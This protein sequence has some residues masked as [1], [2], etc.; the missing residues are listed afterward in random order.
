M[1]NKKHRKLG[2]D[3]NGISN[4]ESKCQPEPDSVAPLHLVDFEAWLDAELE[5]LEVRFADWT[6][7][8]SR[9]HSLGR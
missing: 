8:N 3:A 4:V 2:S 9:K 1:N 5:K 6:T 7:T